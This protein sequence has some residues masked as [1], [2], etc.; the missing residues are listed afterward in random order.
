MDDFN[1]P[2]AYFMSDQD[3]LHINSVTFECPLRFFFPRMAFYNT[4]K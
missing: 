1:L 2:A 4:M 3:G